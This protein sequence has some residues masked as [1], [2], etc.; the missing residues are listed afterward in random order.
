MQRN[1][2]HSTPESTP[3]AKRSSGLRGLYERLA[4]PFGNGDDLVDDLRGWR[5]SQ[6]QSRAASERG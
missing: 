3:A 2:T 5:A 4:A 6:Q 1:Y